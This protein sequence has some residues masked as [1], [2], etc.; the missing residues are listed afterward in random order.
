MTAE[1]VRKKYDLPAKCVFYPGHA[2]YHKNC[3][4]L[5]EG[6]V[7]L[8]RQQGIVLDA[9]F[10]GN[11]PAVPGPG[12]F[13]VQAPAVDVAGGS[14]MTE[15]GTQSFKQTSWRLLRDL[16]NYVTFPYSQC[17]GVYS[18]IEEAVAAAPGGKPI[19]YDHDAL[20][21]VY[22]EQFEKLEPVLDSN[23]FPVLFH[24]DRILKSYGGRPSTIL[25]FGG[26]V[27]IHRQ[28]YAQYLDLKS[29]EW[30]VCEVPAIARMGREICAKI[31]N[32]SFVDNISQVRGRNVD[33]FMA[34]GS[35]NYIDDI[36]EQLFS[37][38]NFR[39]RDFV[40]EHVPLIAGE[41]FVTLQ[42][43]G[44]VSYPRRVFGR[45]DFIATF[46]RTGYGLADVWNF[47]LLEYTIPFHPDKT[48]TCSGMHFELNGAALS[49]R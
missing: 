23:E 30:I 29:V 26:N 5:L 14:V 22:R 31:P 20:A 18:S 2:A 41:G 17:R 28:R 8:E 10:C 21:R 6:L 16:R 1:A 43:G 42:N 27:G 34:I 15:A 11:G 24:L 35:I 4:Y 36:D 9:V 39:P 25:D 33:I 44:L 48:H 47:D 46:E 19:G 32:I 40:L 37:D 45:S 49:A 12:R 7:E 13:R 3:L 38:S